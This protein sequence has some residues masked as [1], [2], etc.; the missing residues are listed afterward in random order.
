[1]YY[2]LNNSAINNRPI[3]MEKLLNLITN[4]NTKFELS[5][6]MN[7]SDLNSIKNYTIKWNDVVRSECEITFDIS[8]SFGDVENSSIFLR[9]LKTDGTVPG[10]I[11][12]KGFSKIFSGN[13]AIND[14]YIGRK[15]YTFTDLAPTQYQFKKLSMDYALQSVSPTDELLK[16]KTADSLT[17]LEE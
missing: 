12:S 17:S 2:P 1:M 15:S 14:Q 7:T 13:P 8:N 5:F 11:S 10:F 6:M 3:N 4:C 9:H 16:G